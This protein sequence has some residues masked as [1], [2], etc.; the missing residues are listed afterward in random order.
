M[1]EPTHLKIWYR[2]IGI[3]MKP[4]GI[5]VKIPPPKKNIWVAGHPVN[6]RFSHVCPVFFY[7][8]SNNIS[9]YKRS[10]VVSYTQT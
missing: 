10:P 4:Q 5:G 1:V 2:Q 7:N 8:N 3:I 9:A 6:D